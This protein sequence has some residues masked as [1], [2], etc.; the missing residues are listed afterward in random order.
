MLSKYKYPT[1]VLF[2]IFAIFWRVDSVLA[3]NYYV[4]TNGSDSNLGTSPSPYRTINKAV[5][6]VLPGDTIIVNPGEYAPFSISKSGNSS[7]PINIQANNALI[8]GGSTAVN[9]SGSYINMS[10]FEVADTESHAVLISGKNI[11]YADFIV[12]DSVNENKSG[13]SCS[14]SGGWGSGLKVMVGAENIEIENGSIFRNCGEGLGITRGINVT[15]KKVV[16]YDNFSVN[17]YLDNSRDVTL[18]QSFSYC[19]N[20]SRYYRDGQPAAGILIG[21]ESYSGWG[22]Q[23]QNLKVTNNIVYGCRGVSFYG[24]EVSNGGLVGGLIANNTIW[25]INGGGRAINIAAEP[26]NSNIKIVNNIAGGTISTGSGLVVSNNISNPIFI[27]SLG[28]SANLFKPNSNSPA[29]NAGTQVGV[30]VDFEGNQRDSLPDVGAFEFLGAGN[31][32]QPP[33]VPTTPPVLLGD[34]NNDKKVDN[35]DYQI[36]KSNFGKNSGVSD[37]N[38]SGLVDIYDYN[39]LVENYGKS[40]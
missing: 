25:N 6:T 27:S 5:S 1:I 13:S 21:E 7:A 3:T 11:R 29:I 9:I 33:I 4:S 35:N 8:S 22:A 26:N 17:L 2:S 19:T 31:P 24:A 23:L 12:R 14:G 18:T 16:A 37:I 10:G 20:D 36:F 34:L 32:T 40:I 28:Y 30:N 15:I 39:I 38:K